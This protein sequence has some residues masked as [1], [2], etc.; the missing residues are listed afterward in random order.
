MLRRTYAWLLR[1]AATRYALA[2]LAA[3]AFLESAVFPIPP[4]VLLIPMVLAARRSAFLIAGV[5]TAASVAGGLG[6]YAIGYYLFESIGRPLLAFYGDQAAFEEVRSAY[7]EWGA[8]IVAAGGFTPIPYKVIT[9]ASGALSLDPLTFTIA[10][11]G[12]RG[13]RFFIEAALLWQFGPPIKQ[14]I[15]RRLGTLSLIVLFLVIATIVALRFA[16]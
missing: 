10:S 9:V 15:E 16:L 5:C 4:D 14:F 13:L 6:G 7:A 2:T 8:W 1:L 3:V 12:S 11:I